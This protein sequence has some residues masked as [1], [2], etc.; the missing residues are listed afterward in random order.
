MFEDRF[1]AGYLFHMKSIAR[2]VACGIDNSG[3]VILII[4]NLSTRITLL[5]SLAALQVA[6]EPTQTQHLKSLLL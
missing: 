6:E 4:V 2:N 3:R 5:I 1:R